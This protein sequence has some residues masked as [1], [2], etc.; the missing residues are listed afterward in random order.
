MFEGRANL[1]LSSLFGSR[2]RAQQHDKE[3]E[4]RRQKWRGQVKPHHLLE[5]V[6]TADVYESVEKLVS[7]GSNGK[8]S[9]GSS[10]FYTHM[11]LELDK[12]DSLRLP[13][14]KVACLLET[15]RILYSIMTT[16]DCIPPKEFLSLF[17]LAIIKSKA[18]FYSNIEFLHNF[19]SSSLLSGIDRKSTRLNSSHV[20]QSRMPSSA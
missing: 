8:A 16:F 2:F 19:A 17:I 14:E 18:S 13:E 20:S 10:L 15:S 6:Q 11:A 7:C 1:M 3:F 4:Q 5:Q 12:L 9:P